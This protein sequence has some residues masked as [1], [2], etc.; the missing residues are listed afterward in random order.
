MDSSPLTQH[1]GKIYTLLIISGEYLK[2]Y[3]CIGIDMAKNII[4]VCAI[5]HNEKRFLNKDLSRAE[6]IKFFNGC[7]PYLIG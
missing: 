3:R 4:Q 1:C 5:V 7:E 2:K 6:V